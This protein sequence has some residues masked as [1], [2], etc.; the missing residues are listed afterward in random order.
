MLIMCGL[1]LRR[2]LVELLKWIVNSFGVDDRIYGY[3]GRLVSS[4]G[5]DSKEIGKI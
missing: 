3:N 4:Y 1:I 5:P 2:R